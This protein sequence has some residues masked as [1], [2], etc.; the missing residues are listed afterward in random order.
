MRVI[1]YVGLCCAD[2]LAFV[3]FTS[4]KIIHPFLS[5]GLSKRL[6]IEQRLAVTLI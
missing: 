3:Q 6:S 4:V 1:S 2:L 5:S